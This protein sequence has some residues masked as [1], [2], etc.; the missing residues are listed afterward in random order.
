MDAKSLFPLHKWN[1]LND[2]LTRPF[3]CVCV[4]VIERLEIKNSQDS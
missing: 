1:I 3:F 2:F 4:C